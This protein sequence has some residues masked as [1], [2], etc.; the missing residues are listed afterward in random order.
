MRRQMK[1]NKLRNRIRQLRYLDKG[2]VM[3]PTLREERRI[4]KKGVKKENG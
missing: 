1:R 4:Q 2:I 3:L